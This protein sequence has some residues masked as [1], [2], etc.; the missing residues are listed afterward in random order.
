MID[1]IGK[2][3]C[4]LKKEARKSHLKHTCI[5]MYVIIL[6]KRQHLT[7]S[8]EMFSAFR[9]DYVV[10]FPAQAEKEVNAKHLPFLSHLNTLFRVQ[11]ALE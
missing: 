1:G 4:A 9:R 7:A 6:M 3:H 2:D 11:C 5:W 10:V 8:T